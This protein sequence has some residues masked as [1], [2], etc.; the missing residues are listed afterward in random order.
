M[1]N[2]LT[3]PSKKNILALFAGVWIKAQFPLEIINYLIHLQK[4][5]RCG[6]PKAKMYHLQTI[7]HLTIGYHL[8]R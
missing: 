1:K 4:F 8:E 6:L 3:F 2:V 5:Q 7:L